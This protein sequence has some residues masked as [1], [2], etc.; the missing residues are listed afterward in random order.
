MPDIRGP[1]WQNEEESLDG[2]NV[3][4]IDSVVA[5]HVGSRQPA[6]C[7]RSSDNEEVALR[8]NHVHG[9]DAGGAGR[10]GGLA[11]PPEAR[12]ENV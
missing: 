3:K 12:D 4:C 5:I 10:H 2:N 8:G 1:G 6:S 7:E 11:R 9:V